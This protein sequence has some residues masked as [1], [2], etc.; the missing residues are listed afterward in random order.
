MPGLHVSAQLFQHDLLDVVS[1]DF[2]GWPDAL[3]KPP[4]EISDSGAHVGDS[5]SAW[6]TDRLQRGIG[7]FPGLA[8][9]PNQPVCPPNAHDLRN[10]PSR[11]GMDLLGDPRPV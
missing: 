3:G 10:A 11:D 6:N 7:R 1:V 8:L 4:S 9:G 5:G 2:P